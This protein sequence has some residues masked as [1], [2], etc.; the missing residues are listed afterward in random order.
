MVNPHRYIL[1]AYIRELRLKRIGSQKDFARLMGIS[2]AYI[3]EVETK[4]VI[5][6]REFLKKA[7]DFLN[8]PL[9]A[10]LKKSQAQKFRL[11]KEKMARRSELE[12]AEAK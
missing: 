8:V 1:G 9:G 10:L 11:F 5:P 2:S 6:S 3:C 7:A 12:K 4:G